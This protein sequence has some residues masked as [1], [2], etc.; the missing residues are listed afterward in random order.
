MSQ[1]SAE[2]PADVAALSSAPETRDNVPPLGNLQTKPCQ[3]LKPGLMPVS[4]LDQLGFK[5]VESPCVVGQTHSRSP[6]E[7]ASEDA[8]A[9]PTKSGG[10][11]NDPT[12]AKPMLQSCLMKP[13]LAPAAALD[14]LG[15]EPMEPLFLVKSSSDSLNH[16]T[17]SCDGLNSLTLQLDS[18]ATL[19]QDVHFND[20]NLNPDGMFERTLFTVGRPSDAIMD[21]IQEH[22]NKYL[23][24][25]AACT[26]QPPQQ[27]IDHFLKQYA[28]LIPTNDWNRYSKYF[29][30]FLE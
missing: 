15:F 26:G 3:P 7:L 14:Q 16:I 1:V 5:P 17:P 30:H 6:S 13:G 11:A 20:N 19:P 10:V 8:A 27:I 21:M 4:A 24:D 9:S 22:I 25:L 28:W 23:T 2:V 18:P 12:L 29:T